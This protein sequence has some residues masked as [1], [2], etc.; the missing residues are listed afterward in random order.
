MCKYTVQV[1][2]IPA[3]HILAFRPTPSHDTHFGKALA[4]EIEA[5]L[6]AGE[7]SWFAVAVP[8]GA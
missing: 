1:F 2:I 6:V 4:K 8:G 5:R 7:R 3:L